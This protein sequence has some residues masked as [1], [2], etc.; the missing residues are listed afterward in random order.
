MSN[1]PGR[2]GQIPRNLVHP[3]TVRR[4][5]DASHFESSGQLDKK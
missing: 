4:G 3:Q 2:I 5:R 1:P